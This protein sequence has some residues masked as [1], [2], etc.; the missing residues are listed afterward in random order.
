LRNEDCK[1]PSGGK[2]L[3]P[4]GTGGMTPS[5]TARYGW[6]GRRITRLGPDDRGHDTRHRP[7]RGTRTDDPTSM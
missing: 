4:A 6:V 7:A 2:I 5:S 3:H 1:V